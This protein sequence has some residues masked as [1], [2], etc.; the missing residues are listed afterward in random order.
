MGRTSSEHV[1]KAMMFRMPGSE[2]AGP[3]RHD[4]H[5]L[6]SSEATPATVLH[7]RGDSSAISMS[8]WHRHHHSRT[9]DLNVS[10]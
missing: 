3:I 9:R 1:A 8:F 4:A 6:R 7:H 10:C 2:T 5:D